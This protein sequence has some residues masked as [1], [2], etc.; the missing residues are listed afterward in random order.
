MHPAAV[1]KAKKTTAARAFD[2][3]WKIPRRGPGPRRIETALVGA[4]RRR[5]GFAINNARWELRFQSSIQDPMLMAFFRSKYDR[6]ENISNFPSQDRQWFISSSVNGW[7]VRHP[8]NSAKFRPP[9]APSV[10]STTTAHQRSRLFSCF[11]LP[12]KFTAEKV[13]TLTRPAQ[14]PS[15]CCFPS[16]PGACLVVLSDCG[17]NGLGLTAPGETALLRPGGNVQG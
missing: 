2:M 14:T 7:R 1:D 16:L 17:P 3:Q 6:A 12:P 10:L 11:L 15:T 4:G 5:S 13:V 8:L 9:L